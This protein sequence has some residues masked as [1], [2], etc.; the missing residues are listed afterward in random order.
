MRGLDRLILV[1]DPAD[2]AQVP[3]NPRKLLGLGTMGDYL[4]LYGTLDGRKGT[5]GL[6]AAA[7]SPL[8]PK[9]LTLLI[10]GRVTEEAQWVLNSNEARL[11]RAEGR[12]LERP[13]FQS[14][15]EQAA[16]FHA[17][18]F[19]WVGYVNH[20]GSS[21]VLAQ[22]AAASKPVIATRE[23]LVGWQTKRF[24]L[25][26]TV[27]PRN[28]E[29]VAA[30]ARNLLAEPSGARGESLLRFAGANSLAAFQATVSAHFGDD[31][32]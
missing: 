31:A 32:V 3:E 4:L 1:P 8:F 18:S 7:T 23:G 6:L 20:F 21:G 30:A 16:L 14:D 5:Q 27:N 17:A 15:E 19:V 12:L 2:L 24:G 26:I 22:A 28:P 11:L 25:G 9:E 29:Q 13:G 10:A